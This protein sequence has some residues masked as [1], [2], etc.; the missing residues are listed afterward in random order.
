MIYRCHNPNAKP[1]PKYG[2]RGI[3]VCDRWRESFE[4]FLEDMGERPSSDHSLDRIDND[5]DYEPGNCRWATRLQQNR[6]RRRVGRTP[7]P[8]VHEIRRRFAAGDV[9]QLALSREFDMS[10]QTVSNIVKG[11]AAFAALEDLT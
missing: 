4:E 10:R 5:G 2:G 8:V 1:F 3:A 11:V 7:M 9:T 6:N